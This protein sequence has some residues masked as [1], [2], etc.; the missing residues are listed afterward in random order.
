MNHTRNSTSLIH[1]RTLYNGEI[2]WQG[3]LTRLWIGFRRK[4]R[5]EG[6]EFPKFGYTIKYESLLSS[7]YSHMSIEGEN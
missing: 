7:W 2:E 5:T 1:N 6:L 3:G 4:N